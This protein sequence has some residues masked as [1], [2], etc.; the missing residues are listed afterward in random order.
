[1]KK[2]IGVA[3]ATLILSFGLIKPN[4][5]YAAISGTVYPAEWTQ[6][7]TFNHY[8]HLGSSRLVTECYGGGSEYVSFIKWESNGSSTGYGS[9]TIPCNGRYT[10][11]WWAPTGVYSFVFTNNHHTI[12]Y[13]IY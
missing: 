8:Q 10:T 13:T 7:Q 11:D 12:K 3:V 2:W 1:M 4:I 9:K 5:T 6:T